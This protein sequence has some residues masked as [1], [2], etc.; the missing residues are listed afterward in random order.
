MQNG[1][2]PAPLPPPH[3]HVT[4]QYFAEHRRTCEL[5]DLVDIDESD[6]LHEGDYALRSR[7]GNAGRCKMLMM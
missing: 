1:V 4:G 7:T 5:A 3:R 2:P 6:G